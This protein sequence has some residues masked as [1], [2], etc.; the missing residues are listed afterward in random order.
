[1]RIA[2]G[3]TAMAVIAYL[4]AVADWYRRSLRVIEVLLSTAAGPGATGGI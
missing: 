1:M 4:R 3:G 2:A